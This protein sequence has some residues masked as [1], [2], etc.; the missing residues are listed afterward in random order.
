MSRS[1]NIIIRD[2]TL[3]DGL[4]HE[5]HY[6]PLEDRLYLLKL[7]IRAGVKKIEVGTLSHPLYL[8]Q[9]RDI[10]NF[11]ENYITPLQDAA[12]IEFTV[13]ALNAKA[14]SRVEELLKKGIRIDRVL[15]GQIATSEAYAHKNMN[16]SREELLEEAFQNV[17]RLHDAGIPK[18]CA[19]VGTVFGCPIQGCIPLDIAYEYTGRLFEMGFDEIEHSDS[20]GTATPDRIHEYFENI[21][22]RWPDADRHI[23]HVHDVRGAG[24]LDYYAAMEEGITN[25]ECCLGGI[26]GQPANILD[27]VPVK[28]TGTYYFDTGHTGLVS[29]EDFV[30]ILNNTGIS[31]GI[32]MHLLLKAG[33]ETEKLLERELSSF[34][35]GSARDQYSA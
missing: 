14:V 34:V 11:L 24:I 30:S 7:L 10:D 19:N 9:F 31:T 12:D 20:E 26:G 2:V 18:V 8:P 33:L 13:L 4:Q 15:T 3:R 27:G 16:R 1:R 25:F 23:F 6:M 32:D 28:G 29:T 21:L 35:V 17:R 5:E 22:A